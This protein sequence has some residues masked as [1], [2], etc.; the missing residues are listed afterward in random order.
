MG[1]WMPAP[2]LPDDPALQGRTDAAPPTARV[3]CFL[4]LSGLHCTSPKGDGD[5]RG[6]DTGMPTLH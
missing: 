5:G 1:I 3:G 6:R 2:I 4:L